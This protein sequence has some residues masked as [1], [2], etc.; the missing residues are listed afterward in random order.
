MAH[1]TARQE[2][3]RT[4]TSELTT[5]VNDFLRRVNKSNHQGHASVQGLE[6]VVFN[7]RPRR[8]WYIDGI[9][10]ITSSWA[11]DDEGRIYIL[12]TGF[13]GKSKLKPIAVRKIVENTLNAKP[14]CDTAWGRLSY[15][16]EWIEDLIARLWQ[17]LPDTQSLKEQPDYKVSPSRKRMTHLY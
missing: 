7:V 2:Q 9:S 17:F 11:V 16:D 14:T 1:S 13:R 4:Y 5:A 15:R 3:I 8:L 6:D 10:P 12:R